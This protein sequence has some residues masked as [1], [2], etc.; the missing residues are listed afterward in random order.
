MKLGE[1]VEAAIHCAALLAGA[2][3]GAAI[4]AAAL[5]A[6]FGLSPS[7]LLKHLKALCAAGILES[8]SGPAGGYRLAR[9]AGDIT[10]LQIVLAIEGHQPAFRCREIRR[11]GPVQLPA[12]A[13]RAPCGINA[14]MLRAERAWR[15]ELAATRLADLVAEFE[16]DGDPRAVAAHAEFLD[17]HSR[18]PAQSA[19][20]Q[21]ERT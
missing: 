2:A 10:L 4:P 15:A 18:I 16:A 13:W 9:A 20:G 5:A 17:R 19:A 21:T 6:R 7:Y 12:S 3:E 14:A 8:L 11:C 1:G